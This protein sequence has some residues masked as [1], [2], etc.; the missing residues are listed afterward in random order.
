MSIITI[1]FIIFVVAVIILY[2][3]FPR[4]LQWVVLLIAIFVFYIMAGIKLLLFLIIT[5]VTVYLAAFCI[6]YIA[7]ETKLDIKISEGGMTRK[8]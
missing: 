8:V 3:I 2:F 5:I 4:R 7:K 6:E 1:N